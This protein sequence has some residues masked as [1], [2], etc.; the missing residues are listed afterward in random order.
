MLLKFTPGLKEI[1]NIQ[2]KNLFGFLKE[3][4]MLIEMII[5]ILL[6]GK[7]Q[8]NPH[9]MQLGIMMIGEIMQMD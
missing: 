4:I 3:A 7:I 9:G 8:N 6:I 5:V 2:Q 1:Y